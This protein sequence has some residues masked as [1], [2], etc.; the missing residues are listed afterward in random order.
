MATTGKGISVTM[1]LYLDGEITVNG[2]YAATVLREPACARCRAAGRECRVV[3]AARERNL[4]S[5]ICS[6]CIRQRR[7]CSS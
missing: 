3:D 2:H 5:G 6:Y 7:K 4:G 1:G